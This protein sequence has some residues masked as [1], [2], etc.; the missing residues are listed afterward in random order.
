MSLFV[1]YIVGFLLLVSL[2]IFAISGSTLVLFI[3]F[4]LFLIM[5]CNSGVLEENEEEQ[6]SH[7]LYI[8][9]SAAL[10][11]ARLLDKIMQ[12]EKFYLIQNLK[13]DE[14]SKHLMLTS[15]ELDYILKKSKQC[16]FNQYLDDLRVLEVREMIN[17]PEYEECDL[18]CLAEAC[19]FSNFADFETALCRVFNTNPQEFRE[20]FIEQDV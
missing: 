16:T 19:G 4:P 13:I 20:R 14:I 10:E 8:D 3:L 17:I 7:H 18:A 5:I 15:K 2:G 1:S 11:Y 6:S 12:R 9:H